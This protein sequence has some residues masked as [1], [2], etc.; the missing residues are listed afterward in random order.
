MQPS[1]HKYAV[2]R[3]TSDNS[4]LFFFLEKKLALNEALASGK[5][6]S[7]LGTYIRW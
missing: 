6:E 4:G 7:P 3:F 1:M 2:K 5:L